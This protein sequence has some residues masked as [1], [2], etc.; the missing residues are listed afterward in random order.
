LRDDAGRLLVGTR[1]APGS[2][3]RSGFLEAANV[4][5]VG[6]MVAMLSAQRSFESAEKAVSAIDQARQKAASDVAKVA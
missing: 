5:A 1:L 2:S 6:Q 3:V 4:D